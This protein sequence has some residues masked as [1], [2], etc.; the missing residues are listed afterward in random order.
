[1][2]KVYVLIF[3]L[4]GG[5]K[6][7][8]SY[9]KKEIE[10]L[11]HRLEGAQKPIV[12]ICAATTVVARAPLLKDRKHTSNSL[13]YLSKAVPEYSEHENYVKLL[14]TRDKHIIT[15]SG[16]GSIEFT[17]EIFKELSLVSTQMLTIWYDAFKHGKNPESAEQP[18]SQGFGG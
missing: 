6:W 11:L 16:L 12:A 8:G 10:S 2:G 13:S 17:I 9:P 3:I 15:A 5:H 4:P 14:A 18:T 1:M 7:E